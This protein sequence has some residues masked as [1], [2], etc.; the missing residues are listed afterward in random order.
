MTAAPVAPPALPRTDRPHIDPRTARR[1]LVN[2][3][4]LE[5]LS[6][7]LEAL[8][9]AHRSGRLRQLGNHGPGA[10]FA[11]LALAM[12]ASHEGFPARATAWLRVLGPLVKRRVLASPFRPG[13]RLKPAVDRQV[14]DEATTFE[15]G[16]AT[17]RAEIERAK[18]ARDGRG[19]QPSSPHPFFGAMSPAEWRAYYLRHAELHLSFLDPGES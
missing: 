11:H 12:R 17:L 6:R 5:A 19:P 4:T 1:R 13:L 15:D 14:W 2:L 7:D 10:I 18:A 16:L 3:A 9:A 8:E